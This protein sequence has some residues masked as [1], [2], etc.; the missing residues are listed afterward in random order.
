MDE[1][2]QVAEECLVYF[3]GLVQRNPDKD[4]GINFFSMIEIVGLTIGCIGLAK[5]CKEGIYYF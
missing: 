5:Q 4:G 2:E 1:F 3:E